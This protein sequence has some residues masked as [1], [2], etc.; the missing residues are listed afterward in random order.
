MRDLSDFD[1]YLSEEGQCFLEKWGLR[2]IGLYDGSAQPGGPNEKRFVEVFRN[3]REPEGRSEVFWF[4]IVTINQLIERC[5]A[6]EAEIENEKS[7]KAGL[8][9]RING[10]EREIEK[11]VLPIETENEQLK[12]TLRA[13]WATID[14]YE[15]QLGIEKPSVASRA[16]DTCPVCKGTG[17]MGNCSRCDGKGY[18]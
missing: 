3:N 10:Q 13:C 17:G 16:G 6:L 18:L 2:L 5:V 9:K 1:I 8:I 15:K 14:K 11:R 4:N 12:E 7:I